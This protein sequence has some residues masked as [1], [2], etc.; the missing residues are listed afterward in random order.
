MIR[1]F[2]NLLPLPVPSTTFPVQSRLLF[3]AAVVLIWC[4]ALDVQAADSGHAIIAAYERFRSTDLSDVEAGQLL[5]SE[6]NCQSC[7]GPLEGRVLPTRKAPVLT[8][9][10][11]RINPEYLLK[12]LADPQHVKPGTT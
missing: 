1:Q 9:A 5:L 2:S 7:H 6:L 10:A 4:L 8:K 11:E 3:T 12:F